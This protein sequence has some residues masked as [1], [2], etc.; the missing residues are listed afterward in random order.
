MTILQ[1]RLRVGRKLGEMFDADRRNGLDVTTNG[2]LVVLTIWK[3]GVRFYEVEA[4]PDRADQIAEL[5][6][7]GSRHIR[8]A[9]GSLPL[10]SMTACRPSRA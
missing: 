6:H 2:D 5:L 10:S 7:Q 9:G 8:S 1:P 4:P 3:D